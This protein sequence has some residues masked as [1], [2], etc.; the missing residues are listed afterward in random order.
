VRNRLANQGRSVRHA[1]RI[2][3]SN[4]PQVNASPNL[5]LRRCHGLAATMPGAPSSV[6]EGGSWMMARTVSRYLAFGVPLVSPFRFY[7]LQ[8]AKATAKHAPPSA[9]I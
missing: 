4:Q 1:L 5:P 6:F 3:D 7:N 2:L 9:T 8:C